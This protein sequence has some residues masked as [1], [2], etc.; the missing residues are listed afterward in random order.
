MSEVKRVNSSNH[1]RRFTPDLIKAERT[2]EIERKLIDA[3][4]NG[5]VFYH[6][7]PQF[8]MSHK[9]R[10]FEALARMK[11]SDGRMISPENLSPW[12]RRWGWWTRWTARSS[13]NR[14][15]S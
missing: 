8:D 11:D 15:C 14:L 5:T 7:Q 4:E 6:L 13:A 12:R 10:G 2:L 1:I 9:L 3:L